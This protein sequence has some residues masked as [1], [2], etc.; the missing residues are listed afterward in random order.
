MTAFVE[1]LKRL[2]GLPAFDADSVDAAQLLRPHD[3]IADW[4]V[5]LLV[6]AHLYENLV[7]TTQTLHSLSRLVASLK[8]MKVLGH[9]KTLLDR[10]LDAVD[11]AY[12]AI[13]ARRYDTALV[14]AQR[15]LVDA[16]TAFFDR[17]MLAMLYYPD[18]HN[19][20]IY[21]SFFLPMSLP[22]I[23]SF[24]S[25]FKRWCKKRKAA[26]EAQQVKKQQ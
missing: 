17:D 14:D 22:Y 20:A 7:S 23:S 2:L 5:D 11:R 15:A 4:Q 19:L 13:D 25:E 3:A 1:Q 16:E 18:E 8:T 9:I 12:A 21:L 26:A 24:W 10:S 6:R